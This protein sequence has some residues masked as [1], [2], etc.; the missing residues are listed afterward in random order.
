MNTLNRLGCTACAALCL[1]AFAPADWAG[2]NSPT[3]VRAFAS[4]PDWSGIWLSAAWPL[5]VSGRVPGGEAQLRETLQLLRPPPY[6]PVWKAKYEA[7]LN[8]AAALAARTAA[9]KVCGRSF[10]ALMEG[11]W[12]FQVVVLPEETL[13]IFENG[14]VRHVYTDGRDH[15]PAEELW[16]TQLGDSVGRW[17]GDTLIID[18]IARN[19]QEPLAPRAWLSMLSDRAHFTEEL[20][21]I[22][23][24]QLEVQLTIDDPIA[25]ANPWHIQLSFKR[26]AEMNRMVAYDCTENDRNPLVDGK[27]IIAA[28]EAPAR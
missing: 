19:P 12:M 6:N 28:P 16:P 22:N 3:R 9:F 26:V 4:L 14:Q 27:L 15:P 20:R 2:P 5:D 11:P 17:R 13:L 23:K 21:M 24:D 1:A 18:T 10:P 7:G 25:L 8:N